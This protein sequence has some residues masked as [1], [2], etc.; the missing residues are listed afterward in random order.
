[1]KKRD[2]D[3]LPPSGKRPHTPE[4]GFV[5]RRRFTAE[6]AVFA[7]I[8]FA[9][10]GLLSRSPVSGDRLSIAFVG[11]AGRARA[12]I[13]GLARGNDVVALCDVDWR[14]TGKAFARFPAAKRYR[15]FR[16][17]LDELEKKID[18]VVVSTPDHTHAVAAMDAIKRGKHVYCE[19]P[20]AHSIHEV[21]SLMKAA[22]EKGVVTQ[23]GNQGHSY[24][25][26]RR[27]VEWVRAGAIGRVHTIH[28]ACNAVHC[29]ID[30]LPRRSEKHEIPKEVNWD[31]WLGP[32]AFRPYNPMYMP[33]KWRGWRPFGNGTIGDWVCHVVDPSFWALDLG[34]PKTI[35]AVK[36]LDFDPLKH[37]E[38]FPQGSIIKFEFPAK[39]KR[40]PVT[41]YWYGG[42]ERIPRPKELE[43][44]RT[45]PRTGA[46]LIGDKGAIM[47]GSHGAAGVRLI[48][49][50]RMR[51]FK[52]PSPTIPRVRNHYQDFLRAVREGGRAGSDFAAYGG[53]LTEIALLGIISMNFPGWKLTWDGEKARFTGCEEANPYL[54]PPYRKGW[55][56]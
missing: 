33:H 12:N 53:P 5:S 10:P 46:V 26:I 44:G 47:H 27:L 40:G 2:V 7:G 29:R 37:A 9:A 30:L 35:Q 43:P 50:S 56:L 49:E 25:D 24:N 48:P 8:T 41:L 23:L 4:A 15:D 6:A 34:S 36:L 31:L 55:T 28:A 3:S 21:R 45:P 18:I 39:G 38:T 19:K 1:M 11:A 17:M 32:A 20:L 51:A 52:E 16:R 42:V 22:R 14:K 54:H 13:G